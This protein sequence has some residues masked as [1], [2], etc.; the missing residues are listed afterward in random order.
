MAGLHSV[1]HTVN[2]RDRDPFIEGL[3]QIF[4]AR[5]DIT[6][7]SV[8]VAAGLDNSTI[9]KL[10]SGSNASPKV[11]TAQRIAKAMGYSLTDVIR[12]GERPNATPIIELHQELE[13]LPE[14]ILQEALKYAQ[15]LRD[16]RKQADSAGK[17]PM[18]GSRSKSEEASPNQPQGLLAASKAPR[19][20]AR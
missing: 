1:D 18:S 14:D 12:I 2:M 20:N 8:S 7:A 13:N 10:L 15:Y 19:Q 5:T 4:E 16:L 17:E 3:R 6:P 9:R 11:E